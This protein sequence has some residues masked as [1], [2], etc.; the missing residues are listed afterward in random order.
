M[1][2]SITRREIRKRHKPTLDHIKKIAPLLYNK[3]ACYIKTKGFIYNYRHVHMTKKGIKVIS[4]YP[5]KPKPQVHIHDPLMN[6]LVE[7]YVGDGF[8]HNGC[9]YKDYKR[10][11]KES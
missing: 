3:Y 5:K 4:K 2:K 9:N 8:Q 10:E 7:C 1:T 11:L 6:E